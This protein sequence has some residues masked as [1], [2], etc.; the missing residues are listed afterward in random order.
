MWFELRSD[1]LNWGNGG[2]D[3]EYQ[4]AAV[5][6]DIGVNEWHFCYLEYNATTRKFTVILDGVSSATQSDTKYN[7]F[8]GDVPFGVNVLPRSTAVCGSGKYARVQVFSR[9][10]SAAEI[11]ALA[12]EFTPTN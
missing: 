6:A 1:R 10:L 4:S 3:E 7:E 9:R 12:A 5:M 2:A 11:A 8:Y